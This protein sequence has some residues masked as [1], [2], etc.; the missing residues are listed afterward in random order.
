M[1][2]SAPSKLVRRRRNLKVGD[3]RA[4]RRRGYTLVELTL[5]IGLSLGVSGAIVG[6]L[7]QHSNF[8]RILSQFDFLRDDAP[9]INSVMSRLTGQAVSYRLYA[10]K[11]D[12][13]ANTDAV[14]TGGT[15]LRLIFRNPSGLID[16]TVV[17]FENISGR[18]QLNLYQFNGSWPAQKDWTITSKATVVT[19]AD[20]TGILEMTLTGP[21]AEQ[22]TYSA[23][24]E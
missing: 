21:Q 2:D 7:T 24:S 10:T 6:V 8:M 23:T 19:F 5:A 12:A 14:N 20:T 4:K 16:Q 13:F 22:I 17:V 18:D 9:Q 11:A 1:I 15:A 3:A